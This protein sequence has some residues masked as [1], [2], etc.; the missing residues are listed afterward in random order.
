MKKQICLLLTLIAFTFVTIAQNNAKVKVTWGGEYTLPKKHLDVGFIGNEKDGYVQIGH[1]YKKSLS[2]QRFDNTFKLKSE[3]IISLKNMPKGYMSESFLEMNGNYYWFFSTWDKK[4]ETERLFV[5]NI[6]VT[7]GDFKGDAKEILSAK[8]LTGVLIA[9]GFYQFNTAGKWNITKSMD[10]ESKLMVQY[11]IKPEEKKDKLNKDVIGLFVFNDK[12]QKE[13]GKEF[14]MP[15]TEAKMDN[16]DYYVD[17]VGNVY[18]LASILDDVDK[19]DKKD[20]KKSNVHYEILKWGKNDNTT[21]IIPFKFVDKFIRDVTVVEDTAGVPMVVGLYSKT[22]N[23]NSTDGFFIL[24]V[25][26]DGNKVE[27][28]YKGTY[29]IP[30]EIIKQFESARAKRKIDKKDEKDEAEVTGLKFR[31]LNILNDGSIIFITEQYTR[32]MYVY[33]TRSGVQYRYKHNYDDIIVAK[34][35]NDGELKYVTKIP[36]YQTV[37]NS[38]PVWVGGMSIKDYYYNGKQYLL[39]IDNIKN[40]NITPDKS[41]EMHADG[42]GGVLMI[43]SIDENGKVKKEKV[44]DFREEKR[45]MIVTNFSE[46]GNN[47]LINRTV[48]A[49][50]ISKPIILTFT[51]D[52]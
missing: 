29:E 48:G 2:L 49:K 34:I 44:F 21:Q 24:K 7:K 11:R 5:Q 12:M 9:T 20:K 40:L 38:F 33:Y 41:P 17:R 52:K 18:L 4:T 37:T 35:N 42:W 36:K 32:Y 43:A 19:A 13:W 16:L 31:S 15:Y 14:E 50:R 23:S 39:F 26:A 22:K 3:K 10:G 28:V 1:A 27:N 46:V 8:K 25:D 30:G 6:D 51:N 45:T 47:Q